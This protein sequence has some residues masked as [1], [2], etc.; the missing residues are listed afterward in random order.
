MINPIKET[1][2]Y[3]GGKPT[4]RQVYKLSFLLNTLNKTNKY[5]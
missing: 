3:K 1:N 2:E 4:K 5:V